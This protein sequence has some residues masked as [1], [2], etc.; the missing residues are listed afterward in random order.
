MHQNQVPPDEIR[1]IGILQIIAGAMY[2]LQFV[3]TL[4]GS[5]GCAVLLVTPVY[6]AV[7]A[8][9]ELYNGIKVVTGQP[10]MGNFWW[11]ALPI[12]AVFSI[13]GADVWSCVVGAIAL[14]FVGRP[15]VR[16]W[17]GVS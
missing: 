1:I 9:L 10:T 7:V 5:M 14:I 2:G 12:M 4:V 16:T 3:T 15:H 11:R 13:L 17:L 8:G 6:S